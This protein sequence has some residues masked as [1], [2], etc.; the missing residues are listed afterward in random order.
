MT[1]IKT[2][3][4]PLIIIA[5]LALLTACGGGATPD[6]E[7]AV[8]CTE[9]PFD[10]PDM[11]EDQ[12]IT[13]CQM[14]GT[15]VEAGGHASCAD[16]INTAC[17]ANPFMY[18]GC[19][20]L[21]DKIRTDFCAILPANRFNAQCISRDIGDD[22]DRDTAC[23]MYGTNVG[24]GGHATCDGRIRTAC[25][26]NPFEYKGCDTLDDKIRTDFCK[27]EQ[28]I[29]THAEC[30]D[31]DNINDI[32]MTFCSATDIFHPTCL[33]NTYGGDGARD[34]ACQTHGI[35]EPMGDASCDGRIRVACTGNP[36]VYDGCDT[37]DADKDDNIRTDF[38]KMK[39]NIFTHEEC[40]DLGN[41][42][43]LRDTY[44]SVT[45]IFHASC[46]NDDYDGGDKRDTACQMHGTNAGAGGHS[47]C[48]G[49][50]RT[51]CM[52]NPFE[53]PGCDTL[54]NDIRTKFCAKPAELFNPTCITRKIGDHDGERDT[55]CL[56]SPA[57][58]PEHPSCANRPGVILACKADPFLVTTP[59][60]TGCENLATIVSIRDI[61]CGTSANFEGRCT[62]D[63][64]DWKD[65]FNTAPPT[66]PST[67]TG[68]QTNRFLNAGTDALGDAVTAFFEIAEA[69]QTVEPD[70]LDFSGSISG[71]A[72]ANSVSYFSVDGSASIKYY[73]AGLD[74]RTDLGAPSFQETG[75]AIWAGK[76]GVIVGETKT[77]SDFELEVTFG[78]T[79]DVAGSIA[80]FVP[81]STN[82]FLLTG[83][84][85]ENGVISGT[86]DFGA[87]M[88]GTR[89][90]TDT[91][92]T[93]KGRL[94][95]LIGRQGAIGAFVSG[96]EIDNNGVI[97]GGTS[98]TTGFAGGFAA[99]PFEGYVSYSDWT[100]TGRPKATPVIP[101]NPQ[102]NNLN[103]FVQTIRNDVIK[104]SHVGER[105]NVNLGSLDGDPADGFSVYHVTATDD[106][107]VG[108][109]STTS[110]GV[111][112]KAQPVGTWLG[113]FVA[114]E[115]GVATTTPFELMVD[116]AGLNINTT[117]TG[118]DY[119]FTGSFGSTDGVINGNVD[120][121][122]ITGN[123]TGLIGSEGAVGVFHSDS[124]AMDN[125]VA[126]S[127]AGGFVAAFA[128]IANHA[129][130]LASFGASPP[131]ATRVAANA[132]TA[133]VGSFLNLA[134]GVRDISPT[135][136]TSLTNLN[137]DKHLTLDGNGENGMHGVTYL[138]GRN[139]TMRD[140]A[141][142]AVLPT[143]NLGAPLTQAHGTATWRG[144]YYNRSLDQPT[145]NIPFLIN[146][147]AKT[148]TAS[149]TFT[150]GVEITTTFNL[151]FTYTGVITGNVTQGGNTATARGLIGEVGL[152]G[153]FVDE[154]PSQAPSTSI[155]Y[156]GFVADN[157]NN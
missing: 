120:R 62:V 38:C 137:E 30:M 14:H 147:G 60:N 12:K 152:V 58:D 87:F 146:F 47:S 92:D 84:Y 94:T 25:I 54:D 102:T 61:H 86:V 116:F 117:V 130:W 106:Y 5:G 154:N 51:A 59:A 89:T 68:E 76:F 72:T 69:S 3:T 74:S 113:S 50:I 145:E 140:Q 125:G 104:A 24:A 126:V 8:D 4:A 81:S 22:G 34:I 21:D 142:V 91:A 119:S 27:M 127:Y 23:Q 7:T 128:P 26:A 70:T 109:S 83:T 28:H 110:L 44:C 133:A 36:F 73:Y 143:T 33:D 11:C 85:D 139:D 31:L 111:T 39:P 129:A 18:D 107:L 10:S 148:I 99:E 75:T 151:D 105:F 135:S 156:G 32:R 49:R 103:Q 37:L 115:G 138:S 82:H 6:E 78:G 43:D 20:T 1:Y 71:S 2:L 65:S 108:L 64:D 112:L 141:F 150:V 19:D 97:T 118:T 9:T 95:G 66:R 122:G 29:F 88:A 55:A 121:D 134:D 90:P 15:N 136:P 93:R 114:Y 149:D 41:I 52:L 40:G 57:G 131:P 46:L 153:V 53:Y 100:G 132:G 67:T 16:R 98:A 155:F 45:E 35:T 17:V 77:S 79:D 123:L 48:D 42:N 96:T 56:G 80:A 144:T 157:P 101:D 124:N 13:A 63:Y